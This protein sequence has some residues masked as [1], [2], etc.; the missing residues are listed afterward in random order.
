MNISVRS[1]LGK[2]LLHEDMIAGKICAILFFTE[3]GK[4]SCI[5]AAIRRY[6]PADNLFF[7]NAEPHVRTNEQCKKLGENWLGF[8]AKSA[9]GERL[10]VVVDIEFSA[11]LHIITRLV[12]AQK[13]MFLPISK[14]YFSFE[15][16][17]DVRK[18]SVIF[19]CDTTFHEKIP[20]LTPARALHQMYNTISKCEN[21]G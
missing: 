9:K 8:T 19:N 13:F 14:R 6:Y 7:Q 3:T 15:R 12:V 16:I 5:Q 18:H 1:L 20:D 17:I 10:G 4:L 11:E 21:K 2:S